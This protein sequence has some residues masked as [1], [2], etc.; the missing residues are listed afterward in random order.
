MKFIFVCPRHNQPFESPDFKIG[1]N[2]GVI[3][4]AAGHKVLDATVVL[5]APC[6]FCGRQHVYHASELSCPFGGQD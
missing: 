6:P 2:R 3:T 4:D 5:T 1:E